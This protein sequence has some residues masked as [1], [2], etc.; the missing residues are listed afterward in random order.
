MTA[1]QEHQVTDNPLVRELAA[2]NLDPDHFVIFGSAPLLAHGLR[3]TVHDL[4]VVA[5]G[6]VLTWAQ[7]TGTPAIGTHSG[8]PV[9]HLCEGRIQV[10]AGWITPQW[11]PTALIDNADLIEGLRFARLLDVLHYK[12]ELRRPKDLADIKKIQAHLRP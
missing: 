1:T 8:D 5:R 2:L 10:S 6:D 9:W 12:Q 3:T 4:D 7:Q 11:N